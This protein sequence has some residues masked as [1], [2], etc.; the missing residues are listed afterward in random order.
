MK[1][2]LNYNTN[3]MATIKSFSD[4]EQSKKLAEILPL[5]SADMYL[6]SSGKRYYIEAMDDGD[7][8]E[9]E[10]HVRAWSLAALLGVMP[11]IQG[12]KPI[13]ALDDNYITYPH[14]SDLHTKT[15]NLVDACVAM[16]EKLYELKML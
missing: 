16:I 15:D 6:W 5:E 14:M 4:L 10:G 13:I 1:I 7:F 2:D 8:N 11:E 3:N 9:E 12:G